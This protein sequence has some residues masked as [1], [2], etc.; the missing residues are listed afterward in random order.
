MIDTAKSAL[1]AADCCGHVLKAGVTNDR[2][3]TGLAVG[4]YDNDG[5]ADLFVTNYGGA[6]LYRSNGS[7][8]LTQKMICRMGRKNGCR[9]VCKAKRTSYGCP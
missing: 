5:F 8:R 2:W 7:A 9:N 4:D 1:A 6:V 3:G